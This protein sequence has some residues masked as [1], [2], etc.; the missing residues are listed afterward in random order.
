MIGTCSPSPGR[1][2][3][4]DLR[5]DFIRTLNT[6]FHSYSHPISIGHRFAHTTDLPDLGRVASPIPSSGRDRGTCTV[7]PRQVECVEYD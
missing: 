3:A 1:S 7:A 6:P 2:E 5:H 4:V